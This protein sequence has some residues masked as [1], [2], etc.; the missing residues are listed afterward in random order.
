MKKVKVLLS[1][2]AVVAIVAGFAASKAAN[3]FIYVPSTTTAPN[4]CDLKVL[5]RSILGPDQAGIFAT[6]VPGPCPVKVKTI[7]VAN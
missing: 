4:S 6:N 2:V 3:N 7:A 1:A 5:G